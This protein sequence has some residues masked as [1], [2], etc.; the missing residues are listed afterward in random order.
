[1]LRVFSY[2]KDSKLLFVFGILL[3]I[4]LGL[5]FPVFSIF[6]SQ[7][8][9]AIIAIQKA[10]AKNRSTV[11]ERHSSNIASLVFVIL[12]V[13]LFILTFLRE[14]LTYIVGNEITNNIRKTTFH[15]IL[16]MPVSWFDKE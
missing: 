6:L 3:N 10:V 7:L 12:A 4:V 8:L 13:A 5:V 15:K 2:L 14:L 16:R 11:D 1:M 9:D